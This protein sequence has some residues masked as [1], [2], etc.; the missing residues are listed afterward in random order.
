MDWRPYLCGLLFGIY[1]LLAA[2]SELSSGATFFMMSV[3]GL[4]FSITPFVQNGFDSVKAANSHQLALMF[5]S[6]CASS[7]GVLVMFRYIAATPS[8]KIGPLLII[9]M[10]V[11]VATTWI[12]ASFLSGSMPSVREM[13][14][15]LFAGGAIYLLRK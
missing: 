14:G 4:L 15:C 10:V 1:P 6:A 13:L 11:Q 7:F 5:A 9:M 8:E 12:F 2:R 3:V